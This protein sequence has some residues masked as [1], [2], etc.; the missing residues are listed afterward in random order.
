MSELNAF[1]EGA[2]LRGASDLHMELAG[3]FLTV[4]ERRA[5]GMERVAELDAAA[6][7]QVL[8]S[9]QA[10]AG[11]RFEED[12]RP[13]DGRIVRERVEFRISW[14][15]TSE[16]LSVVLRVLPRAASRSETDFFA[17]QDPAERT[18][19][20]RAM[21]CGDGWILV[22]G[23]TGSGKT[24]TLYELLSHVDTR[25]RKVIS[26]EDP[27]ERVLPGVLQTEVNPGVDWTFETALRRL[28]RHDPDVL[29]IGELRDAVSAQIAMHAAMTG[30]LILSTVHASDVAGV[31]DRLRQLGIS[32]RTQAE[33][34][35][36]TIAQRL[37]PRLCPHC[38]EACAD[39]YWESSGCLNC[40]FSK[41][42]GL[43]RLAE[44]VEWDRSDSEQLASGTP[45]Y[46]LRDRWR[47]AGVPLLPQRAE[48]AARNGS[49]ARPA[50]AYLASGLGL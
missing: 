48:R 18:A 45:G 16:G 36:L 44:H 6:G 33:L 15:P 19:F 20:Q 1:L 11:L 8:A 14:L 34:H 46:A 41:A 37:V 17:D 4:R 13:Q 21:A 2:Y 42:A 43:H 30:H 9:L 31:V 38:R 28:L 12:G 49:I 23:P 35:R 24:T 47:Q 22:C 26:V 3:G 29:L 5:Q 50:G 39:D 25:E 32:L 7:R 10:Q 40:N 27:V